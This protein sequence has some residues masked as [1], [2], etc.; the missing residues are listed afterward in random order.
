MKSDSSSIHRPTSEQ[1]LG[2]DDKPA[3]TTLDVPQIDSGLLLGAAGRV[4]IEHHGQRYEL[5]ETR[6]GKLILTK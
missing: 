4:V 3:A 5:R 2:R 6:Y 1:G